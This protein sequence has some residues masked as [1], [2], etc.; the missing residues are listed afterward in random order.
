MLKMVVNHTLPNKFS[1]S[2]TPLSS[3][4]DYTLKNASNGTITLLQKKTWTNFKTQFQNAQ[5]LLCNQLY[6]TKQAGFHSNYANHMPN[7]KPQTPAEYCEALINLTSS[8]TADCELLT[9]LANSMATIHQHINQ[10]NKP[11]LNTC[12]KPDDI[13]TATDS[14]ALS[15]LITSITHLQQ[16]L[17]E[18]KKENANLHNNNNHHPCKCH[19]NA[20]Y[21][22]THG[23]HVRNNHTRA[24]CQNK[25]PR[26]QDQATYDNMM[27]SSQAN[28]PEDL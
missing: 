24:T 28:K 6:T 16:Q 4:P 1:T 20:N 18:L 17:S 13:D 8:A 2:P 9:T 7:T 26:H 5:C 11:N 10:L 23:Y 15:S 14:T 25:A 12:N 22:W 3:K 21:C 27:G 19:D